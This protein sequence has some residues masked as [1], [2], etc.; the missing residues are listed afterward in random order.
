MEQRRAETKLIF[1]LR[2]YREYVE[3]YIWERHRLS[4]EEWR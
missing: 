4:N 2:N 1:K 3:V